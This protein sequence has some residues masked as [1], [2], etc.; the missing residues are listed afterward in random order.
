MRIETNTG[1]LLLAMA[2]TGCGAATNE[3]A[4]RVVQPGAP[5][6]ASQV[7][8]SADLQGQPTPQ[9]SAADVE[10]MRGMI[11]HHQQALRMTALVPGRTSRDDIQLLARRIELTQDDEISLMRNWLGRRGA[12]TTSLDHSAHGAGGVMPHGMLT[13][14]E[15]EQL[16]EASGPAF[17]ELF[18]RYMIRHHEGAVRMVSELFASPD[19]GQETEVFRFASAVAGDQPIEI[20]RMQAL[21]ERLP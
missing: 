12:A 20:A 5:G 2:L 16:E 11:G 10:F 18:L 1:L 13:E 17:D 9:Y 7:R 14:Q 21:L 15:F 3:T 4:P 8:N 6:D 19:G